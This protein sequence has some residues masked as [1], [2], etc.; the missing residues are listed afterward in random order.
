MTRPMTALMVALLFLAMGPTSQAQVAQW[1]AGR[2]YTLI[3]AQRTQV[4]AGKVE[5]L[6]VFSYGCPH[7]NTFR[8]TIKLMQS[9]LPKN[10]QVAYLPASWNRAENWPVF[11]RAYITAQQLGVADKAHDPMFDAIWTTGELGVLDPASGRPKRQL[12]SIEDVAKFYQKVAGV[13]AADF[14]NASKSFSVD[15]KIRQAEAQ[16]KAMGI[17]STPTIVVNGKYRINAENL[18]TV[19]DIIN[20]VAFLVAKENAAGTA[21]KS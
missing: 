4:P 5:V 1:Q 6:E 16:I 21:K 17:A 13:K 11:Q 7:C 3:P 9:R 10:A 19:D 12:P 20:V 14:V 2:H 15:M 18:R 8:P